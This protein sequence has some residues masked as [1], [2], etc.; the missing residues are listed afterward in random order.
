MPGKIFINYRRDD[1]R[2]AAARVRDRLA[3]VF[4]KANVFMD[5]DNLLAGQRFD[6]ELEKAL[7]ETDVFLAVIGR[8]WMDLFAS[9]QASGERDFVRE[10]IAGALARGLV[11]IPVLL[12]R[13]PLPK[14]AELPEDI[15]ELVMH[16]K[17]D[18]THEHFGREIDDLI[19]AIR[20]VRRSSRPSSPLPR[21]LVVG[22]PAAAVAVAALVGAYFAGFSVPW[23]SATH[24]GTQ[25]VNHPAVAPVPQGLVR[26]SAP[27]P[28]AGTALNA[29]ADA[30]IPSV[31][32]NQRV[33]VKIGVLS[34][35][36]GLYSD[37][38]GPG[39]VAAAKLAIADFTADHKN[40]NVELVSGDHQN[41]PE[42]G[43][44]LARRWFDLDKVDMIVDVPNSAVALAVS[45]VTNQENKVFIASG[46]A[47]TDLTGAKCN[48]N[49]V[50]WT[51]DT[52][53]LANSTAGGMVKTGGDTW[54]FITADYAF[55]QAFQR[56]AASVVSA[57][58]GK[59][60]GDVL[61]PLGTT[62]FSAYLLRAQSS[63]AKVIGLADGGNDTINAIK[64]AAEF[65]VTKSGQNLAGLL[66]YASDVA[67]LGLNT[68]QGVVL[69]EAWYWDMNDANRAWTKRWQKER[70]GKVP[71]MVQA[72]V[73]SGIMHY[74]KAVEALRNA[75]DGKAVVAK[76]KDLPTD[77]ILFGRG[78]IR[79]DGRTLHPAYLFEVKKPAESNHPGDFY[80]VRATIPAEEAFRPL[81]GSTCPLVGG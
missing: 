76:M 60:L 66:V 56:D 7:A 30:P 10:E 74:L 61:H 68:A 55:G 5:V 33:G 15:R 71:T 65:G 70:P 23:P 59:V 62:D 20:A 54:F 41:K 4:G 43:S 81:G 29:N 46:A 51:Y 80:K 31:P 40:I 58:G 72:G 17:H 49:T 21:A 42:I 48:A 78:S 22:V 8:H 36:T 9:R 73:Y 75:A 69:S 2:S 12:E 44:A 57:N 77:D 79:A 14:A 64:Q 1:D 63:N 67:A 16:H 27:P 34:D 24:N 28:A 38:G 37:V 18:V 13:A 53:M 32:S 35:M 6:R 26:A 45:Q 25:D 52:R 39:S 3:A 47:S 19:A 50:H 11:V